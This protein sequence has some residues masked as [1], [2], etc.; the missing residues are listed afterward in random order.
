LVVIDHHGKQFGKADGIVGLALPGISAGH[1]T[2]FFDNLMAAVPTMPPIFAMFLSRNPDVA[3]SLTFGGVEPHLFE[4]PL[5]Y[6][7][8]TTD[9]SNHGYWQIAMQNILVDDKPLNV[10]SHMPNG[11]CRLAVDSGTS[12]ITGPPE[13]IHSLVHAVGVKKSCSNLAS[14]P[15]ITLVLE[16]GERIVMIPDDYV[17]E[18]IT[19][20]RNK[21]CLIGSMGMAVPKPRGPLWVLGDVFLRSYYTVFNRGSASSPATIAFARVAKNSSDLPHASKPTEPLLSPKTYYNRLNVTDPVHS[22]SEEHNEDVIEGQ[23]D[24]SKGFQSKRKRKQGAADDD[25]LFDKYMPKP[26]KDSITD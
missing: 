24:K 13:G 4:P 19:N 1:T 6:F 3:G 16:G 23:F 26:G 5:R 12:L 22:S 25:A 21:H 14:L 18:V 10:C 11:L 20:D 15:N 9:S 7:P 2:P 17:L 8:V